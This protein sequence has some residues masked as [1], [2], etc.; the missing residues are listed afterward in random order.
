MNKYLILDEPHNT[1]KSFY[2]GEQKILAPSFMVEI[3]GEEDIEALL[4]YSNAL[5][6]NT[7]IVV[8]AYRWLSQ[9]S[10][11]RFKQTDLSKISI[12][13]LIKDRPI[14]F[15]EPPEF[16][17]YSLSTNLVTYALKGDKQKA[18]KFYTFLKK[19]DT[20]NALNCLPEFFRPFVERQ[21]LSI[22]KDK[23]LEAPIEENKKNDVK[24]GWLDQRVVESY[25]AHMAEIVNDANKMPCAAI[26]PTVPPLLR[27]SEKTLLDRINSTNKY[28][29]LLCKLMS[30]ERRIPTI[31]YYHLYIDA[32]IFENEKEIAMT[33]RILEKGLENYEFCGVAITLTDYESV[34]MKGNFSKIESF[35]NDVVN[36]SHSMWLP[37]IL[38]RSGWFGLY[39]TD[40]GVQAFSSLMNG[41]PEYVRGGGIKEEEDKYGKVPLIDVCRELNLTEVKA[42]L[43][44]YNEFPKVTNLPYKPDRGNFINPIKY[45]VNFSKPMRL[46]HVEEARR[47][48]HGQIGNVRNPAK[49]YFERSDHKILKNI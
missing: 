14:I 45:R 8:P 27:H 13:T 28:T 43:T 21:I 33:L 4:R 37:V 25:P 20:V 9:I 31:C 18:K 40:C 23:K 15:Y 48:R 42:Y 24:S 36:I 2:V 12:G 46:I 10:T 16:F 26:V 29:A 38:F 3:K 34:A 1:T 44:K 11:P 19:K 30:A 41:N 47:I 22:Y 49:R 7:P 32:G 5:E 35:I 6:S 17:R 39:L